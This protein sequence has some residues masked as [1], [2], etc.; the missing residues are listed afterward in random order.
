M[1]PEDEPFLRRVYASTRLEELAPLGWSAE[2]QQ[3][4]LDQQF[5]A[6]HRHYQTYYGDAEFLLI[7]RDAQPIGRLYVARWPE[8]IALI[9]IAL[10]PEYRGAG[11]GSRLL[12]A[13]IDEAA[14]AGKPLRIHVEKFNPALRLYQRLGFYPIED[15]GIY[16][17]M[18]WA[19]RQAAAGGRERSDG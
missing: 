12:R 7:L 14:A 11:I 5:D 1:A 6:Q 19:A 10:L 8:Q 15:K 4:F 2:Q 18:E 13:L 17:Y 3:A 9:D 16:W